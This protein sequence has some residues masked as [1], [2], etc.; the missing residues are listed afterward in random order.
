MK[1]EEINQRKR[2]PITFLLDESIK[3]FGENLMSIIIFGSHA[4]NN[5]CEDS[6]L[7]LMIVLKDNNNYNLP[8]LRKDFLLKFEE[9]LDLH[10]FSKEDVIENFND[11][12]PLFS[13]LLLG[14]RILFDRDM[15]FKKQFENFVK[16]IAKLDIRYCE[17]DKIWKMQQ[18]AKS[19]EASQ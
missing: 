7:D 19:L 6:D 17:G 2:S 8:K 10:I 11:C 14:K 9:R 4:R 15:F 5:H 3:L 13:T 18:I 1:K 12:S 16:S